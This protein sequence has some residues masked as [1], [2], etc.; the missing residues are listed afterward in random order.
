MAAY[1][2]VRD[3]VWTH[4]SNHRLGRITLIGRSVESLKKE[5]TYYVESGTE[6]EWC[7]EMSS[8][9]EEYDFKKKELMKKSLKSLFSSIK[10]VG[11]GES[12][13]S[14]NELIPSHVTVPAASYRL[15]FYGTDGKL[16]GEL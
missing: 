7:V 14:K 16:A 1:A 4:F 3:F 5:I 9:W 12:G 13:F 2:R 8:D 11:V 15:Q 6:D 10:R